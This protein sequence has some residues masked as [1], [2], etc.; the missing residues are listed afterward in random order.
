MLVQGSSILEL[1]EVTMSTF[2]F[3][4]LQEVGTFLSWAIYSIANDGMSEHLATPLY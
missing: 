1:D 4:A 3:N 2:N